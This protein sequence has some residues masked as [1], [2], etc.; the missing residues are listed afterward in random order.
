MKTPSILLSITCVSLLT[1]CTATPGG[2]GTSS[3]SSSESSMM[4][5]AQASSF[6]GWQSYG[7]SREGYSLQYPSTVQ[8]ETKKMTI[9]T[10]MTG[11]V[12]HFPKDFQPNTAYNEAYIEVTSKQGSCAPV[13]S[14]MLSGKSTQ[15]TISGIT[16]TTQSGS[17]VGA[18]NLYQTFDYTTVQNGTCH[19]FALTIHSCN[20]GP[21][22][23]TG[24]TQPLQ[25]EPIV[26]L[27]EQILSTVQFASSSAATSAMSSVTAST[28][29]TSVGQT[30]TITLDSNPT[31]GFSW[32]PLYDTTQLSLA[33][34]SYLAPTS[35]ALG[36]GGQEQ[37]TFRAL[38][39]GGATITFT[40]ARSWETNVPPAQTRVYTVNVK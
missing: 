35:S 37:F 25:K 18:G 17:D 6:A 36:A 9:V 13:T 24:H 22:C 38:K 26:N 23:G 10:Q 32:K 7:N 1:A 5:S 20:L 30:F 11:A 40:Y 21:D 19:S 39:R 8:L 2:G 27:F 29:D 33:G 31:T 34:S 4:S 3:S 15:K 28:I 12:L 16:Y 14:I